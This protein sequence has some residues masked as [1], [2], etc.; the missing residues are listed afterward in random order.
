M[1]ESWSI[2]EGRWLMVS[3]G[4]FWYSGLSLLV[5]AKTNR[6][7]KDIHIKLGFIFFTLSFVKV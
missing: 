3:V 7:T 5:I 2:F 1:K 4:P 6:P